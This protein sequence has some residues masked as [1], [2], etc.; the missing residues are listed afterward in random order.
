MHGVWTDNA[1]IFAG[2][3]KFEV[4]QSFLREKRKE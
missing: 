3:I 4:E 2:L 1:K